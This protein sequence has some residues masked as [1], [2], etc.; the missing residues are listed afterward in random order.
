MNYTEIKKKINFL[1]SIILLFNIVYKVKILAHLKKLLH[2]VC[3]NYWDLKRY[4]TRE[5]QGRLSTFIGEP[6]LFYFI[7]IFK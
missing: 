2:S 6:V 1:R 3:S 5:I 7:F 4:T